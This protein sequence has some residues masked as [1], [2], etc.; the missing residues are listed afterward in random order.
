MR[1]APVVL[2]LAMVGLAVA[3]GLA[4]C[5]GAPAAPGPSTGGNGSSQDSTGD[6]AVGSAADLATSADLS[7]RPLP[8]LGSS[9]LAGLVDCFGATVCDPTSTFCI[10]LNSGTAAN[11]GTTQTP[12]CYQPV[13]CMGANMNCD[14][15]TQDPV[16]GGS[17]V[18]CVDHMD[19]TYDC[20][21][22]P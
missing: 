7:P 15:I 2:I 1:V 21:A 20:Y 18:N 8:D 6:A 9:D 11:P 4:G 3:F 5:L 13:D 12:A 22:Q 19:G 10:R 16:L 14:C 17:C